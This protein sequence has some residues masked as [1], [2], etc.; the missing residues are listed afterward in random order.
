M[1]INSSLF[2]GCTAPCSKASLSH[3]RGSRR[4]LSVIESAQPFRRHTWIELRVQSSEEVVAKLERGFR[5]VN[6]SIVVAVGTAIIHID[7]KI[8]GEVP[9]RR[10]P[11]AARVQLMA[12]LEW[13]FSYFTI[14]PMTASIVAS[15][16][17]ESCKKPPRASNS[18]GCMSKCFKPPEPRRR[19]IFP[20]YNHFV[21][22]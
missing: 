20:V 22:T 14:P 8:H 11:V 1:L 4:A 15:S 16:K 21:N 18:H 9:V 3:C 2:R 6:G 5:A 13:N 17:S 10:K 7:S 12:D 19:R